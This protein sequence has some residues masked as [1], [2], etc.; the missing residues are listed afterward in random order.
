MGIEYRHLLIPRDNT[1]RPD[2]PV[3]ARLI[4][5]WRKNRFAVI[6]GSPDHL[7]MNYQTGSTRYTHAADTGVSLHNRNGW[8]PFADADISALQTGE[9]ILQWPVTNTLDT[10]LRHPLGLS[11]EV[12]GTYFDLELHLSDDF[13]DYGDAGIDPIDT[14][15]ACGE[16]LAYSLW[17]DHEADIFY[18]GRV[19]RVCQSC[20][21]AFRPQDRPVVCRDGLTG[22]ES[23][24]MGGAVYRFAIVVDCGKCWRTT[25]DFPDTPLTATEE[26]VAVSSEALNTSLYQLGSWS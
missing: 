17:P 22:V 20:G 23:E 2:A 26:F 16:E 25:S 10:G 13:V 6:Q 1:W 4:E 9:T 5:A 19:R 11:D 8:R 15:C 18:S 24:L 12:E 14:K 21:A 3:I 7:R